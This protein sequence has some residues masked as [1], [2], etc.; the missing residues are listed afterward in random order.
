MFKWIIGLI[1]AV[2]VVVMVIVLWPVFF[3]L[4]IGAG[5]VLIIIGLAWFI[6]I[7]FLDN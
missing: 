2:I 1:I 6:K 3:V 4:G 7:F 5:S